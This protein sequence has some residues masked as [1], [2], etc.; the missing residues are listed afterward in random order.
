MIARLGTVAAALAFFDGASP[1][2]SASG[3]QPD[4]ELVQKKL[5]RGL[6]GG[7]GASLGVLGSVMRSSLWL[8]SG[9][10]ASGPGASPGPGPLLAL[11]P[12][13]GHS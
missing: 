1:C 10:R 12:S 5:H 6:P 8:A 4:S 7:H 3:R 13:P 11:G 2:V 9:A